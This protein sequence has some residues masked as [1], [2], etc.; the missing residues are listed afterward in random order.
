MCGCAY[1]VTM[2]L[3]A[4]EGSKL[5]SGIFLSSSPLYLLEQN[6]PQNLEPASL[7]PGIPSHASKS[8]DYR[9]PLCLWSFCV[10][11]GDLNS[12][13]CVCKV[14]T[15]ST[16]PS[17]QPSLSRFKIVLLAATS[18]FLTSP[19]LKGV[20]CKGWGSEGYLQRCFEHVWELYLKSL[21]TGGIIERTSIKHLVSG[22]LFIKIIHSLKY[23]DV[24]NTL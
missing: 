10:S 7:P 18:Y 16:E 17:L 19:F 3:P 9:Q 20:T 24:S 15:V 8:W 4:C 12:G 11:S 14:S 5:I 6:L 22:I 13:P 2:C 1:C 23:A 21:S